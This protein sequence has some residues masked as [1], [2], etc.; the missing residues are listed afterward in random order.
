MI[1]RFCL[2]LAIVGAATATPALAQDEEQKP[3]RMLSIGL[4]AQIV[5][6][7]PGSDEYEVGPLIPS[8]IRREGE[9]IPFRT[10]DDGLGIGLLGRDSVIDFG[11]LVQFQGEREDEDVGAAVGDVDFTVEA[12]AFVNF[13][14]SDTF[15]FRVEGG[16]GIGGHEG[17]VGTV[18][19][20][21]AFRPGN[22]T[23]VTIGPRVRL[24]DQDYA[25]AYFG[26]TPAVAAATGLPAFTPEGGVRALGVVAGLTH[27]LSRSFGIYGYAGYERLVGDAADSPIVQRFGSEDQFSAGLALFVTFNIG[28]AF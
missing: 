25:Q 24:N 9:Q 8:F 5:P 7:Y 18:A 20:D 10:P 23:L 27:Q 26:I 15:R 22:D 3:D 28:D 17:L 16:K 13:N 19:A 1:H 2:S 6:S 11:P 12:G 14:I 21:V 4:G